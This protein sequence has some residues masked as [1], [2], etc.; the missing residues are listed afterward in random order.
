MVLTAI[1]HSFEFKC[2]FKAPNYESA[3][4][5]HVPVLTHTSWIQNDL[6]FV[7]LFSHMRRTHTVV[8]F[9]SLQQVALLD[10]GVEDALH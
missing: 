3:G 6:E 7:P 8:L 2:I 10:S 1:I 4:I 5:Q 9:I